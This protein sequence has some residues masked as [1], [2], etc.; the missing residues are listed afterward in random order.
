MTVD[1]IPPSNYHFNAGMEA[2][3]DNTGVCVT[4]HQRT[5]LVQMP[6]RTTEDGFLQP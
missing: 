6:S 5:L 4:L 3:N 2:P 1:T